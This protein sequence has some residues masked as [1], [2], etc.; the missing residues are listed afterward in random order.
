M[1][2]LASI[3]ALNIV[4]S[5]QTYSF[6]CYLCA[7]LNDMIHYNASV[8][9]QRDY[10]KFAVHT[11]P[12]GEPMIMSK[13][14]FGDCACGYTGDYLMVYPY[15]AMDEALKKSCITIAKDDDG[16]DRI[17]PMLTIP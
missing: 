12:E 3:N 4:K 14:Q 9:S 2:I 13:K 10:V 16:D 17:L 7:K 1:L 8:D 5:T 15:M 11:S 6:L